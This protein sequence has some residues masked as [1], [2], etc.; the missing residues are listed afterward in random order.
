MH[1]P[2]LQRSL[3]S[4]PKFN[5]SFYLQTEVSA[6]SWTISRDPRYFKDPE[7]FNPD[8]WL[9]SNGY[10]NTSAFQPFLLGPRV[11]LGKK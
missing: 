7:T 1:L 6:H 9:E 5:R 11:C 3:L 8:R 2:S 10:D 4:K